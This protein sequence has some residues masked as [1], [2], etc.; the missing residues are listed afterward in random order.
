MGHSEDFGFY[1]VCD[2]NLLEVFFFYF[3]FKLYIT[4][5][6]LPNIKM[7]FTLYWEE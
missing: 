4:V 6:V 2:E 3:I 7:N 1:F 5:L